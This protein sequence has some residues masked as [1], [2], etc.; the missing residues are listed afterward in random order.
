MWSPICILGTHCAQS[1]WYPRCSVTIIWIE[2]LEISVKSRQFSYGEPLLLLNHLILLLDEIF[3]CDRLLSLT[4]FIMDVSIVI[5]KFPAQFSYHIITHT[6]LTTYTWLIL[7]LI[8]ETIFPSTCRNWVTQCNSY[9]GGGENQLWQLC[10]HARSWTWTDV[11]TVAVMV[12]LMQSQYAKLYLQSQCELFNST[13]GCWQKKK[14]TCIYKTLKTMVIH[15][16]IYSML[17]LN[18][19]FSWLF[20][21]LMF[22]Y[23]TDITCLYLSFYSSEHKQ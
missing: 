13:V 11:L 5:F 22:R 8:S 6:V 21:T 10:W 20:T 12:G 14:P 15:S 2:D 18:K 23:Y 16:Y 7:W 1:F 3:T 19:Y 4:T 17:I 9:W